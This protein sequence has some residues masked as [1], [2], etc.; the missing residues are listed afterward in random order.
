M[1]KHQEV[2]IDL[3]DY[4]LNSVKG[5]ILTS[6]KVQDRNTFENPNKIKPAAFTGAGI[7]GNTLKVTIPPFSVIVFELK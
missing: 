7:S 5:R 2:S 3:S 6:A 1:N 4:Q